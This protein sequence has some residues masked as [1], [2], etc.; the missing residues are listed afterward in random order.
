MGIIITSTADSFKIDLNGESLDSD[1]V[2]IRYSSIRSLKRSTDN[3]TVTF[4]F[5]GGEHH[6]T[7]FN[8]VDS[9]DGD[10]A[11]TTQ[12]ILYDKLEAKIFGA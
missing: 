8:D 1:F 7:N 11:I 9:I 2:R 5:D 6:L 4:V 3:E 12:V 10:T